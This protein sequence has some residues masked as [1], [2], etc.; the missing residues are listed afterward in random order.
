MGAPLSWFWFLPFFKYAANK[1]SGI[2]TAF[3]L[4]QTYRRRDPDPKA[5]DNR[6]NLRFKIL[7]VACS[8][9][10]MYSCRGPP[11][12]QEQLGTVPTYNAP[13]YRRLGVQTQVNHLI[14]STRQKNRQVMLRSYFLGPRFTKLNITRK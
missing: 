4:C 14:T 9:G 7:H 5:S 12:H 13:G 6:G 11:G 1:T 2:L 3:R 10:R 8:E